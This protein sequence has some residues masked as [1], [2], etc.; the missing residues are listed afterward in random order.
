M[1]SQ[2]KFERFTSIC[3]WYGIAKNN[4]YRFSSE[5]SRYS[6]FDSSESDSDSLDSISENSSSSE[7]VTN[8][9]ACS[10]ERRF[11][12][13]AIFFNLNFL[14]SIIK[15]NQS[16]CFIFI[17]VY[18]KTSY[19]KKHIKKVARALEVVIWSLVVINDLLC[20]KRDIEFKNYER[21]IKSLYAD[22]E[23]ILESED[24]GK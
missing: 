22:F 5:T 9:I 19:S 16:N 13:D 24:S 21:K 15:M 17:S 10:R 12:Q 1:L 4:L 3:S 20:S 14:L 8:F 6:L 23:S 18:F 7:A 2:H 11:D